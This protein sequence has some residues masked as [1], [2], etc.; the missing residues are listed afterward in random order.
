MTERRTRTGIK[1]VAIDITCHGDTSRRE[2]LARSAKVFEYSYG[3]SAP[4]AN[5]YLF[6]SDY[7]QPFTHQGRVQYERQLAG[8]LFFS[9]QYTVYR[10]DDLSRTRNVNLNPAVPQ[11]VFVWTAAPGST[12]TTE[13][14]T[15]MRHATTPTGGRIR[16]L[17]ARVFESSAKSLY[18]GR[19]S[20]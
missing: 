9:A 19:Q 20:K 14:L 17:R 12:Q 7:K 18:Q 6:D 3:A 13:T 2:S 10:G 15:V 1:V 5:L 4:P 8:N 16:R 11:T